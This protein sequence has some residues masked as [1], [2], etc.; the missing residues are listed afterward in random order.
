MK[1]E[2]FSLNQLHVLLDIQRQLV[3]VHGD[4]FAKYVDYTGQC[5]I[6][7]V[8]CREY[9]AVMVKELDISKEIIK[10]EGTI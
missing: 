8:V 9:M 2:Q 4:I 1:L 6:S 3:N 5:P 7:K 10:R